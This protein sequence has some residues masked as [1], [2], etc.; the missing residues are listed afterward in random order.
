M[1]WDN[2]KEYDRLGVDEQTFNIH[3]VEL[4]YVRI[5][6]APPGRNISTIVEVAAR[7]QLLKEMGGYHSA[8]EFQEL[9]EKKGWLKRPI[10]TPIRSLEMTWNEPSSRYNYRPVWFG[11]EYRRQGVRRSGF[12]LS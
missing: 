7:N 11:K 1:K 12:F 2:E 9:L 8:R 5:P 10:C 6:V 4:P 3:G